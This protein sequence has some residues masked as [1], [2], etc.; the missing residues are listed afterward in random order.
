[1]PTASPEAPPSAE[2]GQTG[3]P[4]PTEASPAPTEP[5]AEAELDGLRREEVL[6]TPPAPP[7]AEAPEAKKPPA[8]ASTG[9]LQVRAAPYATVFLDGKR[10]DEVVGRASFKLAPG[11]YR[12]L[13]QHPAGEKRFDVTIT[14]GS[15]VTREFRAP[16]SR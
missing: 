3:T 7:A 11:T 10:L 16:R 15:T 2:A 12:L 4:A 14:A 6:G 1:V 9:T 13:F 5:D 8:A